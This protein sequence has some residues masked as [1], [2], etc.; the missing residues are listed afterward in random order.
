MACCS[1]WYLCIL[2]HAISLETCY[3]A[4]YVGNNCYRIYLRSWVSYL[5]LWL[6]L[7]A[8]HVANKGYSNHIDPPHVWEYPKYSRYTTWTGQ[9]ICHSSL[10]MYVYT[11]SIINLKLDSHFYPSFYFFS[12]RLE[13]FAPHL[14]YCDVL[15]MVHGAKHLVPCTFSPFYEC[16]RFI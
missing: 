4:S 3:L 5:G 8:S 7:P 16:C 9:G 14:Q 12:Y 10:K 13:F 1:S 2:M 11:F 6:I 15:P